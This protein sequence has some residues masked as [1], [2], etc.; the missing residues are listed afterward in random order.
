MNRTE[1]I[2]LS[3]LYAVGDIHGEFEKLE[4]LL[5]SLPLREGDRL[6]FLGDYVDR[7]PASCEVIERLV[8]LQREWPC[9]FLLGN[10]E[11]MFLDFL[12]WTD[13]SYFGGDAFLM[14][15]GDRTLAS[16][17]FFDS[18]QP[19]RHSF[20]LPK[21]HEDFLLSLELHHREGDYLFVHAGLSRELLKCDDVEYALR[22][23]LPE[24]LLWNR[25]TCD[26][27]HELKVTIVYGHT[28]AEDFN[29]RWNRPFSIGIDTGA[30]YGGPLTAIRLPDETLFQV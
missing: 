27:P 6:L 4:E 7:G 19:D 8:R 1:G 29:V 21:E 10:H 22:R 16:Y 26:L 13:D 28:P 25:A 5:G 14:N 12:G 23:S 11:S 3:M 18:E 2:S 17:G 30:V 9:R 24:D 15:G 20:G